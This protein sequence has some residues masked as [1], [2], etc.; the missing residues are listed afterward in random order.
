[1]LLR[2]GGKCKQCIFLLHLKTL[3]RGV[4]MTIFFL[5]LKHK[6]LVTAF[7]Q[8]L[9]PTF[10]FLLSRFQIWKKCNHT[11]RLP[12]RFGHTYFDIVQSKHRTR[13]THKVKIEAEFIY[14]FFHLFNK[15][16]SITEKK[17]SL[18]LFVKIS[19]GVDKSLVKHFPI[20]MF[21]VKTKIICLQFL[22]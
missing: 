6:I 13:L 19:F 11:T 2:K 7:Y 10:F 9:S 3:Y 22:I 21:L 15:F 8:Q 16:D 18:L 12:I 4:I 5:S 1:M 20:L 14:F 17:V